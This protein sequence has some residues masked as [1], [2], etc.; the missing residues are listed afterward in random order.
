[1][2]IVRDRVT[3]LA[4]GAL[5]SFNFFLYGFGPAVSLLREE[6][7]VSRSVSGLHG[8]ALGAGAVLAGVVSHRIVRLLGRRAALWGGLVVMCGGITF[9][10]SFVW[11]PA[12]ITGAGLCGTGGWLVLSTASATIADHHGAKG[13]AALTEGYALAMVAGLLAPGAVGLSVA[14]GLGW[15]WGLLSTTVL[16]GLLAVFFGDTRLPEPSAGQ[17]ATHSTAGA[18]LPARYWI[19]W[20]S[21]VV[22][23]AI[24]F[25]LTFWSSDDL[26]TRVGLSPGA[27]TSA[28]TA[29]VGGMA[30]GRFVGGRFALHFAVDR[31]LYGAFGVTLAG[32]LT[33]W[34]STIPA[35][36]V[37]GL[38]ITGL[39]L[40]VQFPLSLARAIANAG[41]ATDQGTARASAG[42]GLAIICGP[43]ALGYA[44]DRVGQHVA[45]LLVPVLVVAAATTV[46]ASRA[47]RRAPAYTNWRLSQEVK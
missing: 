25:C 34:A 3:L 23:I 15:R 4:Y 21:L 26:R 10:C 14:L 27:S 20:V 28:V 38:T 36:A 29:M 8:M 42:I 16:A 35:T 33:F 47:K 40:A 30:I 18:K 9:V 43:F 44:A 32:F 13:A 24:E 11:L 45:F 31:L 12:T 22:C 41:G 1:V 7:R 5:C 19:S 17:E 46:R 37:V 6:Q 2:R 39:G